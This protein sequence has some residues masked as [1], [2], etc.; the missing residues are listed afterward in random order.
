MRE[1]NIVA[2]GSNP[3]IAAEI[4]G[5]LQDIL[6]NFFTVDTATTDSLQ[7]AA[8]DTF[9]IC[10]NTQGKKLQAVIP[11]KQ[12]F[13]WE[14]HP[15]TRFFLDIAKIPAGSDVYVFNNLLPYTELLAKECQAL[16]INTLNFHSIAY[17][18][19]PHA[20][21][22]AQ[23]KKAHY[24]IGVECMLGQGALLSEEFRNAVQPDAKII[25]GHRSATIQCVS[26]L[27]TAIAEFYLAKFNGAND[28]ESNREILK[29]V[30]N[31]LKEAANRAVTSR[32]GTNAP[33]PTFE[34]TLSDGTLA[35]HQSMLTYLAQK[36]AHLS[37]K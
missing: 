33:L 25:P 32:L 34:E 17:A 36:L 28:T 37:T 30:I 22:C 3:L 6:G 1:L 20:E 31:T 5:L 24:I 23:L 9:Y 11:Q 4:Q 16:G 27:L 26:Q 12:L 21:V 2:V 19:M 18:E 35:E 10:A 8:S 29:Q 14:L 15:T 13:I 7:K